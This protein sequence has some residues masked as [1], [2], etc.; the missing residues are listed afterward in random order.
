MTRKRTHGGRR[1]GAGRPPHDEHTIGKTLR[2]FQ[3]E[4]DKV[5]QLAEQQGI[6]VNEFIR[7]LVK[8]KQS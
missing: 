6:S 2:M 1:K 5:K 3:A 8:D 4:W 7:R